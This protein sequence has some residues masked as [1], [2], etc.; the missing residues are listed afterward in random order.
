MDT[1]RHR[2]GKAGEAADSAVLNGSQLTWA[3]VKLSLSVIE[4]VDVSIAD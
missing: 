1:D 3:E 4:K 2:W